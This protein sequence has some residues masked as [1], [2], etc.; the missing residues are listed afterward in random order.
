MGE[1]LGKNKKTMF[2]DKK[3]FLF[4]LMCFCEL[5]IASIVTLII[6]LGSSKSIFFGLSQK[7]L[8][9]IVIGFCLAFFILFLGLN[10]SRKQFDIKTFYTKLTLRSRIQVFLFSVFLVILGVIFLFFPA[11]LFGKY[12]GYFSILKPLFITIGLIVAQFWGTL[13]LIIKRPRVIKT[14]PLSSY[15]MDFS[16]SLQ[17]VIISFF[18][19]PG[20]NI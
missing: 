14:N 11:R 1:K 18:G 3:V 4:T 20:S 9:L 16:N 8:G 10:L 12:N 5:I 15:F 7:R 2:S 19:L 17:C 6:S 13:W